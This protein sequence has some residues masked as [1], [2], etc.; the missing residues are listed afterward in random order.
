MTGSIGL[1][2]SA[3]ERIPISH[4]KMPG[5]GLFAVALHHCC[6]LVEDNNNKCWNNVAA[7]SLTAP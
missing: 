6:Q 7:L 1:S 3:R 5:Y 2:P 4:Q